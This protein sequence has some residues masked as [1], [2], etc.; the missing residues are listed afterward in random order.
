MTEHIACEHDRHKEK[1]ISVSGLTFGYDRTAAPVLKS[2]TFDIM[3]GDFVGIIGANGAG[4]STLLRL[5]LGLMEPDG[6]GVR[7]FG[8][9]A[10]KLKE[11]AKIGYVSQKAASINQS[12]PATV[13]EIVRAN[14]FA[15]TG[16]FRPFGRVQKKQVEAALAHVGLSGHIHRRIGELS[17]G[18]QQRVFLARALVQSPEVLYLDEPCVGVDSQHVQSVMDLLRRLNTEEG[19]TVIMTSHDI[20]TLLKYADK[21]LLLQGDGTG[22]MHLACEMGEEWKEGLCVH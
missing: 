18:Q 9:P 3:R 17:G 2:L 22:Q 15:Q 16:L 11:H 20:P 12:F 1:I 7:I 19:I 10:D 14:L 8:D 6:G 13:E 4:K 5:M 21:I